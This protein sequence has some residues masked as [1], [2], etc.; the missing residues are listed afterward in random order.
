[1]IRCPSTYPGTVALRGRPIRCESAAG[2]AGQ[3]GH[4]FAA[5]YWDDAEYRSVRRGPDDAAVDMIAGD[6]WIMPRADAV[7]AGLIR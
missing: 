5:R 7:R 3:H 2:H 1:M 6:G 4:S